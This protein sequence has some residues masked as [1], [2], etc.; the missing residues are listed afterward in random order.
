[1]LSLT[2][3]NYRFTPNW[4]MVLLST[5]LVL[6]FM[7]LGYWQ[8][9]RAEEK[10]QLLSV[11]ASFAKQAPISWTEGTVMPKQYQRIS[12]KGTFLPETILLD[13]QF[14]Q[15]QFGYDIINPLLLPSGSI[16]L[17]DRGWIVG[18]SMR[19]KFPVPEIPSLPLKLIG[20]AYFPSTKTWVLGQE[21]E[22]K[23]EHLTIIE[24]IDTKSISKFLHKPV[25]PFIIRLDKEEGHGYIRDWPVVTMSPERHHAYAFQ[26]FAMAFAILVLF[27]ALNL[28]KIHENG[29]P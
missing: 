25:Y 1:M 18:D 12:V 6:L 27:I 17:V 21:A 11:Q 24:R 3:F 23:E 10:K 15:H 16:V 28:K 8:L 2:C 5:L 9:Q 4:K 20:N 19:Q 7:R 14:Y 22:K 13:N 26:W 29:K